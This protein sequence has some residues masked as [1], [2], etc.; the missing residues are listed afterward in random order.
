MAHAVFK[1]TELLEQILHQ[2]IA[3]ATLYNFL[4]KRQHPMDL[5]PELPSAQSTTPAVPRRRPLAAHS[6]KFLPRTAGAVYLRVCKL[7]HD[8][9]LRYLYHTVVLSRGG[10]VASLVNSLRHYRERNLGSHI[11]VLVLY[12]NIKFDKTFEELFDY[13]KKLHT[14]SLALNHEDSGCIESLIKILPSIAPCALILRDSPRVD[15]TMWR[16][17]GPRVHCIGLPPPHE[18]RLVE[19]ISTCIKNEWKDSLV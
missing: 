1:T 3:Q 7:W 2:A 6:H 19:R 15:F 5:F 14:L 8:V 11:R 16:E 13:T 9:G 18:R 10:R 12:N 17:G 4:T